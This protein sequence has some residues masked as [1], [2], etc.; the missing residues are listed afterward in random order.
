MHREGEGE[1]HRGWLPTAWGWEEAQGPAS[2]VVRQTGSGAQ[3]RESLG[4]RGLGSP[5]DLSDTLEK[6][7]EYSEAMQ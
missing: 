7:P 6:A 4:G 2:R 1:S 3:K 5:D